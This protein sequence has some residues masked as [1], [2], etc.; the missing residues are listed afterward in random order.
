VNKNNM[1]KT[2]FV[3]VDDTQKEKKETRTKIGY[4]LPSKSKK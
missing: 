1:S 3:S 2:K 4:K